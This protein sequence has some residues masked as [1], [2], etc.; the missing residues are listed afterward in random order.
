M[1][2]MTKDQIDEG[3]SNGSLVERYVSYYGDGAVYDCAK[4]PYRVREDSDGYDGSQ[5]LEP[6][7]EPPSCVVRIV[8]PKNEYLKV[9]Y[10]CRRDNTGPEPLSDACEAAQIIAVSAVETEVLR[11]NVPWSPEE[12][13]RLGGCYLC[14]GSHK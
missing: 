8:M 10:Y 4:S 6:D 12:C 7:D 5:C 1:N 9:W 3:L 2:K 11:C 14:G 13:E